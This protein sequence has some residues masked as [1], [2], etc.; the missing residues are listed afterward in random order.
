VDRNGGAPGI[1]GMPVE[2]LRPY[3]RD[4]W[5]EIYDANGKKA[6]SN[7]LYRSFI[8]NIWDWVFR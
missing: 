5:L 3:L 4:N 1:D 8:N 2:E 6:G 7:G